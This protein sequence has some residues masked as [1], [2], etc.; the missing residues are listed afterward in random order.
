MDAVVVRECGCEVCRRGED[1][2]VGAEHRRINLLL[3]RMD[4]NHQ[5]DIWNGS[6]CGLSRLSD[7]QKSHA[8]RHRRYRG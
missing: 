3:S 1:A 4:G 2:D 7:Q 5:P 6:D 8:G